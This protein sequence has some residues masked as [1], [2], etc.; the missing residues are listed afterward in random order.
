MLLLNVLL[1]QLATSAAPWRV[2]SVR[3]PLRPR[4]SE[5]FRIEERERRRTAASSA[6]QTALVSGSSPSLW[7][8]S[9]PSLLLA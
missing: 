7:Q 3:Y 4:A 1:T 5:H 8:L 9:N 6:S 2:F